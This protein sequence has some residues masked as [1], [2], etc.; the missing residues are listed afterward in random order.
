MENL[1][2]ACQPCNIIK[3]K[4]AYKSLQEAKEFVLAKRDEWRQRYQEQVKA[5]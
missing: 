2:T 3:G 5:A 4:R 1:V